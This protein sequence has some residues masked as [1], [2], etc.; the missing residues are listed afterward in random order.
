DFELHCCIPNCI[1]NTGVLEDAEIA[2]YAPP[3]EC[4]KEWSQALGLQLTVNSM[5]CD[6][7][8]N[9]ED[10][11][12]KELLIGGSKK[13][14]KV[15]IYP[16]L[17][18]SINTTQSVSYASKYVPE[19]KYF[20]SA[21]FLD[22]PQ[23]FDRVWHKGLLY[24]TR[25]LPA[26]LYLIINSF[27]SNRTF[28]VRCDDVLSETHSAK[29]GVP[30]GSI[31]APTL[32]NI[33]TSDIPHSHLTSLATFA[34]DTCIISSDP[35]IITSTENLQSHLNDLQNWFNLWRIKKNENKSSHTTFTLRPITSPSVTLNNETIPRESSVKYL[36]IHLDQRLTWATHI[37][38][39]RKSLKIKLHKLRQLLRSKISL[40][41]KTLVQTINSSCIDIRYRNLGLNQKLKPK[42][43][44]IF[45]IDQSPFY[46][47]CTLVC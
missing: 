1:N 4:V 47:K 36:G 39:K 23:A 42:S 40:S 14:L 43:S 45:S 27:L 8:F 24:K 19:R 9:P 46:D 7:H 44:P 11:L 12:Y 2:F 17:P 5:V 10:M 38:T 3:R 31:L 22:V 35:D 20:C 32:Y 21:V 13:I 28:Q 41:D 6:R 37:K 29:A 18:I 25:F 34:D 33:Y 15:L 26:P 16:A 30:Q